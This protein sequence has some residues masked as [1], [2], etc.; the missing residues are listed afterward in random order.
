MRRRNGLGLVGKGLRG[1]PINRPNQVWCTDI[2]YIRLPAGFVYLVAVMDWHSRH[3][4]S[5]EV[6]TT[7][8]DSFCVSALERALRL[9]G[10]PEI[11]NTDQGA[12]FTGTAFTDTLKNA[13]IR[14]SM[15]GKGRA[16]DNIFIERL[17]RSVKYEEVYLNEYDSVDALRRSLKRYFHFYNLERPHQSFDGATPAEVYYGRPTRESC[18]LV[19]E[20]CGPVRAETCGS[21]MDNDEAVAHSATTLPGLSPT[22]HTGSTMALS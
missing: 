3:V 8:D 17:W 15:D 10:K 12:Q 18:A 14:I 13:G 6:S 1:L 19:D 11:F 16:L 21:P 4:L 5:W 7:M 2:T 20:S 9:Y 22:G